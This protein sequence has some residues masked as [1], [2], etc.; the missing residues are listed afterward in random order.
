MGSHFTR[1]SMPHAG[2]FSPKRDPIPI[3]QEA[4]WGPGPALTGTKNLSFTGFRAGGRASCRQL[5]YRLSSPGPLVAY[6]AIKTEICDNKCILKHWAPQLFRVIFNFGAILNFTDMNFYEGGTECSETSAHK[7]KTP[8]NYPEE[9]IQ[10]SGQG[11]S[12]KSRM[13]SL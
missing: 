12:L 10:H 5:L 8:G 7:I 1:W 4:R 3:V 11:E 6:A 9:S 2:R 13:N